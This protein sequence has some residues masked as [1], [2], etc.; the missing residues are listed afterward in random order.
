MTIE[1][2]L[3][4]YGKHVGS[5][6]GTGYQINFMPNGQFKGVINGISQ[7]YLENRWQ[8]VITNIRGKIR[9]EKFLCK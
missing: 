9:T 3:H 4:S 7:T 8:D 2:N 1:Q 5:Y 6:L